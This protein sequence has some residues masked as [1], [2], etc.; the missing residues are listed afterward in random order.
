MSSSTSS[1]KKTLSLSLI[2]FVGV[3]L[4]V[5][6]VCR[7]LGFLPLV[8]FGKY[9]VEWRIVFDRAK[10]SLKNDKPV[11]AFVGDS[12]V[13]WVVD[14]GLMP[15]MN[16]SFDI[17]TLAYPGAS[18]RPILRE[19]LHR[20]FAPPVL[21]IG[22]SHLSLYWS[23]VPFFPAE[24]VKIED[25]FNSKIDLFLTD[26]LFTYSPSL[27]RRG[28][29][30]ERSWMASRSIARNGRASMQYQIA[31][32]AAVQEQRNWYKTMYEK[33][34]P[35]DQIRAINDDLLKLVL[36][37]KKRGSKVMLVRMPVDDWVIDLETKHDPVTFEALTKL[38]DVP[39]LDLNK[40][41]DRKKITYFDGLHTSIESAPYVNQSIA[42]FL[43]ENVH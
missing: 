31:H 11:V 38:L 42:E 28:L 33:P 27:F 25:R 43:Q 41:L 13:E 37:F 36:E 19:L 10:N 18:V 12:R 16:K 2:G 20:D 26:H 29:G 5:E 30:G 7:G 17:Y 6:L 15:S 39:G 14:S 32:D 34:M 22:Y 21:V 4:A 23:K 35:A 3:I 9:P 8:W 24:K 1:F 40:N